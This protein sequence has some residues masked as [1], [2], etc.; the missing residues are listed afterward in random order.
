MIHESCTTRIQQCTA[1]GPGQDALFGGV[2]VINFLI[3]IMRAKR[4]LEKLAQRDH[5]TLS[6]LRERAGQRETGMANFII[7]GGII[8]MPARMNILNA[9]NRHYAHSTC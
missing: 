6:R 4:T 9:G 7:G 3:G 2:P 5:V 1:V 8:A